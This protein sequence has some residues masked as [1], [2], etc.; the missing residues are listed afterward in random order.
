MNN[1]FLFFSPV[2]VSENPADISIPAESNTH[3]KSRRKSSIEQPKQLGIGLHSTN[4]I[5]LKSVNEEEK[6]EE[7]PNPL[8]NQADRP[9]SKSHQEQ[10][11]NEA[12]TAAITQRMNNSAPPKKVFFYINKALSR[13]LSSDKAC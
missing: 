10:T 7:S 12:E 5:D 13:S 1:F 9:A 3:H 4:L 6:D 8:E 11:I 2:D